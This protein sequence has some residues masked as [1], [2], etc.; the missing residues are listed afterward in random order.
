MQE[1]PGYPACDVSPDR[2]VREQGFDRG[3]AQ[4]GRVTRTVEG[5]VAHDPAD[6][7]LV[8]ATGIA[9]E[10]K[11][12]PDVTQQLLGTVLYRGLTLPFDRRGLPVYNILSVGPAQQPVCPLRFQVV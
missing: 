9:L 2:Q 11:S 4:L 6:A 7:S 12:I 3:S 5:N 8:R 1:T 10:A